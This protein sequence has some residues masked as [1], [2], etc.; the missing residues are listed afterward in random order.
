MSEYIAIDPALS[1]TAG[2][3]ALA[4]KLAGSSFNAGQG[5]AG[6][7]QQSDTLW[8]THGLIP[9]TPRDIDTK[10]A[11][12]RV[13][14]RAVAAA[15][16]NRMMGLPATA[17]N[18]FVLNTLGRDVLGLCLQFAHARSTGNTLFMPEYRWP[19][20][21]ILSKNMRSVKT[22]LYA[23]P[24]MDGD[25]NTLADDAK[26]A[27][28][29]A[30]IVNSPHN[31]TGAVYSKA[32]MACLG[33][34]MGDRHLLLDNPYYG[35]LPRAAGDGPY[36]DGGLDVLCTDSTAMPWYHIVSGS[37]FLGTATPGFTILTVHPALAPEMQPFLLA[38]NLISYPIG[39]Y[40]AAL[41]LFDPAND[42]VHLDH[43]ARM[44]GVFEANRKTL[45][46]VFGAHVM[47]GGAGMTSLLDYRDTDLLGRA[48]TT[49]AYGVIAV[50]NMFDLVSYLANPCFA[51][52][53]GVVTVA[54]GDRLLRI[55]QPGK[56]ADFAAAMNRLHRG[57]ERLKAAPKIT[58]AA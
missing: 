3:T 56:P 12:D 4:N 31:P 57:I 2:S 29:F 17:K 18:T 22:A 20:Y 5:R 36:L 9:N 47:P 27:D 24:S 26:K 40:D 10:Y 48:V 58:L 37:K 46:N 28:S 21:D 15:W 54:N 41:R 32:A 38:R 6:P 23:N 55:A 35:A 34:V 16:I 50:Q 43:Y 7:D 49:D 52:A 33:D 39:L 13:D 8:G 44:A 51:D 19:M 25:W 14:V 11:V 30:A 1:P 42:T 45:E 53:C